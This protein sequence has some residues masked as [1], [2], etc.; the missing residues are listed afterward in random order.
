MITDELSQ[1]QDILSAN[2]ES[3]AITLCLIDDGVIITDVESRI[4][5]INEA[6]EA[7]T[8]WNVEE[9]I[10]KPLDEIFSIIDENFNNAKIL[11]RNGTEHIITGKKVPVHNKYGDIIGFV[12]ILRDITENWKIEAGFLNSQGFESAD[13][14]AG[15]IVHKFNNILTVIMGNVSLA[16]KHANQNDKIYEK[17][18]EVENASMQAKILMQRFQAFSKGTFRK[19]IE[20]C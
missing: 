7:I 9:A 15:D 13:L 12:L 16:K 8:G 1:I 6:A 18:T 3:I 11:S 4:V 5:L 2:K 10:N 20:V 19:R 14:I 17:L